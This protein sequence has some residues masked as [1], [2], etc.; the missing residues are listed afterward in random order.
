MAASSFAR[1]A[2]VLLPV[3]SLPSAYGIGTLGT[4]AFHF[5]D[6]LVDLRQRYWQLLPMGPTGFGDSPYQTLSAFAGNPY[7]ID[8][9]ELQREGLLLR[10]EITSIRWG[11]SEEAIDYDRLYENRF[12]VLELAYDR[13]RERKRAGEQR[14]FEAF[15]GSEAWLEP[16]AQFMALKTHFGGKP[17][18]EWE[19]SCRRPGG[20][21]EGMEADL[22]REK[23]RFWKFCQYMFSLQWDRL[24]QYA[25]SKG[26]S[27]IGDMPFYVSHDSAD[28][29]AD[30]RLFLLNEEGDA[31]AV[32]G[33]PADVYAPE[34]QIWGNALYDWEAHEESDFSWWRQRVGRISRM[35]DGVRLDHF[36]GMIRSY[37]IKAGETNARNGKWYKGP[38]KKLA[39]VM[40]DCL[41]GVPVIAEDLGVNVTAARKLLQ[42]MGWL[43]MKVLL[44]A[45]DGNTSNEFLPHNYDSTRAALYTGTHDND[46]IV[47]NYRDKTEYELAFLYEY[48][49]V[50]AREEIPDA[51][52]RLA[53]S[54][55]ADV[56]IIP[57]QDILKRGQ[58]SRLNRPSTV[59]NGNWRW[60]LG[61]DDISEE[62]RTWIRTMSAIYRR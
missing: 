56:V 15:C 36:D 19:E 4:A 42:K 50:D 23:V 60:R 21:P 39:E 59:G 31:D 2:G 27:I 18:R 28:V 62:R 54:S 32:A 7:L 20:V 34:G 6:L 1:G 35:Y 41:K 53:Y 14:A 16:Y 43:G 33:Y 22:F 37:G 12:R 13:F 44:L 26:V 9:E 49:G 10:E 48:L 11:A 3:T 45:F 17:W 58:E 29:W 24:K 8:L 52:I 55:V 61:T 47:G 57:M 5:V 30:R 25:N 46:T 51:M 38:G 40:E